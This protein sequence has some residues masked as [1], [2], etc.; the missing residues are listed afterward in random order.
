MDLSATRPLFR[1]LLLWA[2]HN[3]CPY[4]T[5]SSVSFI[6][7][8]SEQ[9]T[10]VGVDDFSLDMLEGITGASITGVSGY[11]VEYFVT[12]DTGTGDGKLRLN[13]VD[14]DSIKDTALNPL[15]GVGTGNGNFTRSYSIGST[16]TSPPSRALCALTPTQPLP[17][18]CASR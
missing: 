13:V 14:N 15:G 1:S 18:L 4:P 5:P 11:G 2:I 17:R 9:V 3:Y 10:G 7:I 16:R 12:V 6:V 8:F